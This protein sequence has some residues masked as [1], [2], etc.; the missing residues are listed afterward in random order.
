MQ[1]NTAP[2]KAHQTGVVPIAALD[3]VSVTV[4]KL[5]NR[6]AGLPGIGVLYGPPGRGKSM[7]AG[8]M[9]MAYRAYYIQIAA[10]WRVKPMLQKILLEMDVAIP[11]KC[12]TEADLLD[13][14]SSQL[15]ASRRPLI[16][17]EAD[18]LVAKEAMIETVRDI[19]EQSRAPILLIGSENLRPALREY[20]TTHSRVREWVQALPVSLD[21]AAKLATL[22]APGIQIA[23]DLLE[24]IVSRVDGSV[25]Y[26][27][28][29]LARVLDEA[30][31]LGED[32]MDL[33]RWGDRPIY[34]DDT[35]GDA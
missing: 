10:A 1:M 15:A 5:I 9:V 14:V 18:R 23:E 21:D 12:R 17:D 3:L 24:E 28:V 8:A 33:A 19:Y 20:K 27:C 7:A 6:H 30:M 25:R 31:V 16:L 11:K 22:Y 2:N 32:V 35:E 26:T 13:L 34:N 4:E 29:N